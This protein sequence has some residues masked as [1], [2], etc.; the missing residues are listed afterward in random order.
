MK[1]F[2]SL[3]IVK[4]LLITEGRN[5]V[6]GM[7]LFYYLGKKYADCSK[8]S[9][10]VKPPVYTNDPCSDKSIKDLQQSFYS[11]K[12]INIIPR[13]P[14]VIDWR[15]VKEV[16]S[17]ECLTGTELT[18]SLIGRLIRFFELFVAVIAVLMFV[19]GGFL[20]ITAQGDEGQHDKSIHIILYGVGGIFVMILSRLIVKMF[21]SDW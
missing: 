11:S 4:D 14:G 1:D 13:N 16:N 10:I 15:D 21:V 18:A 5:K 9:D 12:S 20:Y 7:A 19:Y 17:E 6:G 3:E 8:K 2:E